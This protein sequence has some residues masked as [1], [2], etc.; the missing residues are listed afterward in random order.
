MND[1]ALELE[2]FKDLATGKRLS[3]FIKW[4]L[5]QEKHLDNGLT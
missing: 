1:L 2:T 4:Q 3:N 5:F